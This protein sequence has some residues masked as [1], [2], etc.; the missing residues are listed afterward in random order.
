MSLFEMMLYT[1][2]MNKHEIQPFVGHG[3][4]KVYEM[5]YITKEDVNSHTL[6]T[7]EKD[8]VIQCI[9]SYIIFQFIQQPVNPVMEKRNNAPTTIL[10]QVANVANKI[11]HKHSSII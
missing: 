1:K 9:W 6:E 3:C 5:F 7:L 11:E 4:F 2:G 8:S 10:A